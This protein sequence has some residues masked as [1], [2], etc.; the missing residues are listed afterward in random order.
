M[1]D[2]HI[3]RVIE[4]SRP[5]GAIA[6]N[7]PT[8]TVNNPAWFRPGPTGEPEPRASRDLLHEQ[9]R[10]RARKEFPNLQQDRKA[11]VLAGPPGAGKSTIRKSVL[12]KD[13][14]K[15]MVIDADTFKEGLLK[16]A[17]SDR[18]YES[19]IKPDA[20][21]A[22]ERETG[23]KFYPMEL[24]SLVHEESSMLAAD[25]RRDAIERGDNIVVDTVL[26][27]EQ[28]AREL[29]ATLHHAG[30]DV[31]VINV[32]VPY[33]VS[34]ERTR[35]RWRED[36]QKAEQSSDYLGGRWVPSEY[37]RDVFNGPDGATKSEHAA[38]I[39]AETCPAVT[40][41]RVYRITAGQDQ[42][43]KD[44]PVLETDKSRPTP[45]VSELV[46]ASQLET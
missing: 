14:D 3:Q 43:S 30:Y 45:G 46:D 39:L 17:D 34:A 1:V 8:A 24:A 38:R 33:E 44:T 36:R 18:S 6:A 10:Q 19:W 29:G 21:K 25:L 27:N 13:D 16:Q 31:Q 26:S 12:G 40:R 9:L 23:E 15:Y 4:L 37:A 28:T 35:K 32:E 42:E 41:Y 11:V 5:G 2:E 7:A 22:L 20:V